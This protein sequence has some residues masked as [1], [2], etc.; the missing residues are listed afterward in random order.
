VIDDR[1]DRARRRG[2]V[3]TR[4][5]AR[6]ISHRAWAMRIRALEACLR[7]SELAEANRELA[8]RLGR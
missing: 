5:D 8:A 7:A 2:L 1:L 4:N 6:A 3:R